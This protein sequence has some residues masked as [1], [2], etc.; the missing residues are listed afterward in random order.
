MTNRLAVVTG[1]TRGIGAAIAKGLKQNGHDVVSFYSHNEEA[2]NKFQTETGIKVVKCD[3]AN[4]DQCLENV[5]K[6]E[7]EFGKHVSILVNNAGITRDVMLHKSTKQ[8]W[9]DVIN[10]N[11]TSCYN[12][13]FAVIKQMRENNF[14]RIVSISSI[15]GQTGQLGQTNYAA[16][17]A[18]IIGFTKSLALESAIKGITVNAIA[19][20]YANTDMTNKMDSAILEGIIQKIP[21][22]RLGTPEE[23][24]RVAL[25]LIAE[26]SSY[27]TGQVFSINGG[28]YM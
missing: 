9:D 12:M 20:G 7:Q 2:A 6:I 15:N 22:K 8:Q 3:V 16:A 13:S 21:M 27:I 19:P 10:N 5:E 1:G 14:G 17:K 24:A 25:F 18:G 23:I 11:L 4:Y 26:E 28:Q